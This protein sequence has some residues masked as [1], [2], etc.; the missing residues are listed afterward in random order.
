MIEK[1]LYNF[2]LKNK[3]VV[4]AFFRKLKGLED[5]VKIVEE[6]D[7]TNMDVKDNWH[8]P[9]YDQKIQH[10]LYPRV[11]NYVRSKEG[12]LRSLRGKSAA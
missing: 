11:F 9:N 8:L 4:L 3:E 7:I 10:S 12:G 5:L 6:I 2:R 1:A